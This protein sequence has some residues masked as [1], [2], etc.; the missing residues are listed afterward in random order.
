MEFIQSKSTERGGRGAQPR[1]AALE[2]R[3]AD[4]PLSAVLRP[5]ALP[6][7]PCFKTAQTALCAVLTRRSAHAS[8]V[9]G[10]AMLKQSV[11]KLGMVLLGPCPLGLICLPKGVSRHSNLSG[12]V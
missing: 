11:A 2:S 7:P 5:N 3:S 6:I 9:V 1:E 4:K 10:E 12:V 8:L